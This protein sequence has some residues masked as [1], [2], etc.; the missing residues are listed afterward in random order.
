LSF[1][2]S[3]LVDF[4]IILTKIAYL[5]ACGAIDRGMMSQMCN[6]FA[7]RFGPSPFSEMVSELQRKHHAELEL[8]YLD[9]GRHY[10]LH[11]EAQV[12]PF[13]AFDDPLRYAGAPPSVQ[14]LKGLFVD[15]LTAHRLF[16]E[17]AQ[18]CLS[19]LVMKVDHT[20]HVCA[21]GA[22]FILKS[23]FVVYT[24]PQVHESLGWTMYS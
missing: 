18:A 15:W 21:C 14:Y 6:T 4:L 19:A 24:V 3:S 1:L 11:G 16:I 13:P 8:M 17:R 12:P 7:T 2:C 5:S 20:F 9:A 10:K 23:H 22:C